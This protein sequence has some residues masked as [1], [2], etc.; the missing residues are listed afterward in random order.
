LALLFCLFVG[1]RSCHLQTPLFTYAVVLPLLTPWSRVAFLTM[2]FRTACC[3]WVSRG[4]PALRFGELCLSGERAELR[5]PPASFK[6]AAVDY[7]RIRQG[8][9][10]EIEEHNLWWKIGQRAAMHL[11]EHVAKSLRVLMWCGAR[12]GSRRRGV[13][14][15]LLPRAECM[16]NPS[17]LPLFTPRGTLDAHVEPRTEWAPRQRRSIAPQSVAQIDHTLFLRT[18]LLVLE[19]LPIIDADK[20]RR[21]KDTY[22]HDWS[23]LP[24]GRQAAYRLDVWKLLAGKEATPANPR[25]DSNLC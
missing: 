16:P 3:S 20:A 6:P 8:W 18:A 17:A 19:A 15:L 1:V 11:D 5:M 25:T 22:K 21:Y 24:T 12:V 2:H 7:T 9:E 23:L 10:R 4:K 13:P 14:S